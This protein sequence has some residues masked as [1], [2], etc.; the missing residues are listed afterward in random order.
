MLKLY[1]SDVRSKYSGTKLHFDAD[2]C[3]EV[4][5]WHADFKS[6]HDSQ[7][8]Q[9]QAIDICRRLA[10]SL[11]TV[12]AEHPDMLEDRTPEQIRTAL[13]R[14]KK[15]IEKQLAAGHAWKDVE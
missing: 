10:K 8:V 15:K 9:K 13:E 2:D 5:K 3:N 14:D 7:Q 11:K 6:D 1:K 4:L 12:L